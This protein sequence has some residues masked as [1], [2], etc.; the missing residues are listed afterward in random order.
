MDNKNGDNTQQL[1]S[2]Q[3]LMPIDES[4]SRL[5]YFVNQ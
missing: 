3:S 2:P 1:K 5:V 4:E